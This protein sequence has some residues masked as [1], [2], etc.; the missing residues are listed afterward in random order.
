MFLVVL[1][2]SLLHTQAEK[3]TLRATL[4]THV[5][6]DKNGWA[7]VGEGS[8]HNQE[9]TYYTYMIFLVFPPVQNI[10]GISLSQF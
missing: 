6:E 1:K 8:A 3:T 2:L 4:C 10:A 7:E 5:N 9:R